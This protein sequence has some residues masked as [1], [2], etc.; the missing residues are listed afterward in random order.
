MMAGIIQTKIRPLTRTDFR[1]APT[2]GL[3]PTTPS[4]AVPDKRG[5]LALC[6]ALVDRGA[7]PCSLYPPPAA[8]AGVAV[9]SRAAVNHGK[10]GRTTKKGHKKET[11]DADL[12]FVAPTV[13]LEP[14]TLRLTAACS[15]D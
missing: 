1:L 4:L 8:L 10:V 15:T 2:V 3:E 11:R 5:G 7:N 12:F 6:L 13:G 14:T 9:N